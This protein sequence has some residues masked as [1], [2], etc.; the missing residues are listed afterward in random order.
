[1]RI[2]L[3]TLPSL[4]ALG[5]IFGKKH[6]NTH[7]IIGGAL[8]GLLSAIMVDLHAWQN[9]GFAFSWAKNFN[10]QVAATRWATGA[11]TGTLAGLGV[12]SLA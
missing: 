4:L 9:D 2:S 12:S 3:L 7:P 6:M 10:W 1:M 5:A 8:A 11:V